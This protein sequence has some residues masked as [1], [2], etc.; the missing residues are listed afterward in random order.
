MSSAAPTSRR[1]VIGFSPELALFCKTDAVE[2]DG[3]AADFRDCLP[4]L[5]PYGRIAVL[6]R[7]PELFNCRRAIAWE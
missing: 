4:R 3:S 6:R 1:A 5:P 7:E 2:S